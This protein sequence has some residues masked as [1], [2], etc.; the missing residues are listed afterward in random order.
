MQEIEE[1]DYGTQGSTVGISDFLAIRN[2]PGADS[3]FLP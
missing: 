1:E 3:V 2:A